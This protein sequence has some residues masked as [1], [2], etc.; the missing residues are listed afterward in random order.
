MPST[1]VRPK[2]CV[3]VIVLLTL[4]ASPAVFSAT[5]TEIGEVGHSPTIV[6]M[7]PPV[8]RSVFLPMEEGRLLA[9]MNRERKARGLS[10]LFLDVPLRSAARAHARDMALW[11]YVGHISRYGLSVRDRMAKF[12]RPGPRVGENLAFVQTSEQGHMA[13]VGSSAHR[14]N[15]LDPAFRRVGIGVATMGEAG[16]MIAEDFTDSVWLRPHPSPQRAWPI[17]SDN[18]TSSASTAPLTRSRST[19]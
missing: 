18:S 3:G 11:G 16:V 7:P 15:M 13:F 9:L 12:V 1:N 19:R 4:T 2:I 6:R 17:H 8:P 5:S 14:Q 10:P